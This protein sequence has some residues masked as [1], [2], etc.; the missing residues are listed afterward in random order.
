MDHV[1]RKLA[2]QNS[3][4]PHLSHD[5]GVHMHV[6]MPINVCSKGIGEE[7]DVGHMNH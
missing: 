4:D 7:C 3:P 5:S 6:T 2:C 1:V